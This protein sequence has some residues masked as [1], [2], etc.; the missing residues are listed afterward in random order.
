M[1]ARIESNPIDLKRSLAALAERTD[2]L[3]LT[4]FSR[5]VANRLRFFG[6]IAV[7]VLVG[8]QVPAQLTEPSKRDHEIVKKVGRL[9]GQLHITKQKPD[10]GLSR[11]A[12]KSYLETLDPQR[13]YFLQADVDGFQKYREQLD[14][15]LEEG[16]F[17]FAVEVFER[18]LERVEDRADFAQTFL[19]GEIDL[20][21]DETLDIDREEASYFESI[22]ESNDLWER[23][24]KYLI[25]DK[26]AGGETLEDSVLQLK[27]RYRNMKRR[28]A[29]TDNDELLEIYLTALTT[30]YDPHTTY[31]SP[32]TLENF[33]ISMRLELEG[34]GAQLTSEDGYTIV[35]EVLPGGAAQRDGRL[36][37]EDKIV[38]VLPE[39]SGDWI[40]VVDMKLTEVVKKIRGKAG[41]PLKL[42]I[43]RK[44]VKER[45]IFDLVRSKVQLQ[46]SEA[47]GE[48][49]ER[50]KKSNGEPYRLGVIEL[51]SFYMDMAAAR[52]GEESFRSTT[53]DV[54]RL[55][56]Q[57]KEQG[58]DAV[59]VDLRRNGGGSLTE[60]INM[61]GL[62]IKEGPVVQVKNGR[63]RIRAYEDELPG[64]AWAGPLVV[65]TSKFSAS[66]SEIF[67]GA[68]QDYRRGIIVGD[69]TTHGKGTVQTLEDVGRGSFLSRESLGALKVT[70]QQFYRPNGAST[71]NRGVLSDIVL[72]SFTNLTDFGEA[73]LDF[74]LPFD[75]VPAAEF[76]PYDLLNSE[77]VDKL[78]TLSEERRAEDSGFVELEEE[79]ARYLKHK[80][81]D[82]VSIQRDKF[83][84]E[85]NE[86]NPKDK[87]EKEEETEAPES[88][89]WKLDLDFYLNEALAITVDYVRLRPGLAV[90]E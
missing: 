57:F 36:K 13:I 41:T 7:V 42:K 8:S 28:W 29:Q 53:A 27:K 9:L 88:N 74:A 21:E 87:E 52:R 56:R 3:D 48:V 38:A 75:R 46:D 26:I 76:K 43:Q 4:T 37:P 58:V 19:A 72:P 68:I 15:Q 70:R 86:R 14:D 6:A 1:T 77:T 30:T 50:G 90:V 89:G 66:A 35:K 49:V 85:Y 40:D 17:G 64:V 25:L 67:A 83:I 55:I 12:F 81:R 22:E 16:D 20:N 23:R 34:I 45:L 39:G 31:M 78:Q 5:A 10:D 2:L 24:L 51:P 79:I 18:F 47:H 63:G 82:I 32:A 11:R 65:L 33:E 73:T 69:E 71:Q 60:A 44:G 80:D 84:A 59:V 61:T 62:F 54:F